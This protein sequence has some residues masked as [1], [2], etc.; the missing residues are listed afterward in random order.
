[1]SNWDKLFD[2]LR[3]LCDQIEAKPTKDCPSVEKLYEAFISKER[4]KDIELLRKHLASCKYCTSVFRKMSRALKE[5]EKPLSEEISVKLGEIN[6]E[7][8][9]RLSASFWE[10]LSK[11]ICYRD[12]EV[13]CEEELSPESDSSVFS[14]RIDTPGTYRIASSSGRVLSKETIEK[15][16]IFFSEEEEKYVTEKGIVTME[17]ET[18]PELVSK[19]WRLYGGVMDID[20]VKGKTHGTLNIVIRRKARKDQG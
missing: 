6:K 8:L 4:T 17:G 1:M 12:D 15:Q 14:I 9:D 7:F 10:S 5:A 13:V 16:D 20:L 2:D 3:K 19:M 18:R 11:I